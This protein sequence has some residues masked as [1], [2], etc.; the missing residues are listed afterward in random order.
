[1]HPFYQHRLDLARVDEPLDAATPFFQ[2]NLVNDA[3]LDKIRLLLQ[4]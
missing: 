2:V 3:Q 1:M 4:N